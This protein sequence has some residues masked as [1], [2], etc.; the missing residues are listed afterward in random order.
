MRLSK[1]IGYEGEHS[2][3][4]T[5]EISVYFKAHKCRA[6]SERSLRTY[7]CANLGLKNSVTEILRKK[8]CNSLEKGLDQ[9]K[10]CVRN[11]SVLKRGIM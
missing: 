3:C 7:F 2:I 1:I 5:V 10:K 9:I 8:S 6:I 11:V 4:D